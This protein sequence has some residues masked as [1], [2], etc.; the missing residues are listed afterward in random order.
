MNEVILA[1]N[2]YFRVVLADSAQ[3]LHEVFRL[4]YQVYCEDTRLANHH[5]FPITWKVMN[6]TGVL[7]ISC[8][9]IDHPA[10]S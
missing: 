3:L 1:F 4:R 6:T 7:R 9:N 5:L 2:K 10:I 8:F